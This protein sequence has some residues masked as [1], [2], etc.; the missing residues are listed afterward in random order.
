MTPIPIRQAAPR[1]RILSVR[2]LA[3]RQA[4]RAPYASRAPPIRP[5]RHCCCRFLR[6]ARHQDAIGVCELHRDSQGQL[7]QPR[8]AARRRRSLR[9]SGR[10]SR[11]DAAGHVLHRGNGSAC[12]RETR[13]PSKRLLACRATWLQDTTHSTHLTGFRPGGKS[14]ETVEICTLCS[15]S[16]N[17]D[18]SFSRSALRFLV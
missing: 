15:T 9:A 3:C 1:H 12:E 8:P 2:Q 10:G 4:A 18:I 5:K 11:P 13:A 14:E 6:P 17:K 16:L 7:R